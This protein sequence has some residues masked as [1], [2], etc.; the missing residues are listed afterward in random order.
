MGTLSKNWSHPWA[1]R[2]HVG[3]DLAWLDTNLRI[4]SFS[5]S[6]HNNCCDNYHSNPHLLSLL[7]ENS[8]H[9]FIII[10]RRRY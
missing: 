5:I 8:D 6:Q 7:N 2:S 10:Y 1:N 3:S 9:E 4:L